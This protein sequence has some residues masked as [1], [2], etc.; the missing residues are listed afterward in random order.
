MNS[1]IDRPVSYVRPY[2]RIVLEQ[3]QVTQ[4]YV[5]KIHAAVLPVYTY[6]ANSPVEWQRLL[7]TDG[8]FT[9]QFRRYQAWCAS[10]GHPMRTA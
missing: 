3:S 9:D 5:D 2:G 4:G 6:T 1:T 7:S 8:I 10:A